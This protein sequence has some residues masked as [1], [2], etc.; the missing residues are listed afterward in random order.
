MFKNVTITFIDNIYVLIRK[1]HVS[2][3]SFLWRKSEYQAE[4]IGR[5]Y[6]H[7]KMRE[8]VIKKIT[9]ETGDSKIKSL[10]YIYEHRK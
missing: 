7:D 9:A 5:I 1:M 4:L 6:I 8:V 10:I 2:G 3:I